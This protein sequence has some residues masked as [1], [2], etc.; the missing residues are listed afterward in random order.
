MSQDSSSSQDTHS[1]EGI[2]EFNFNNNSRFYFLF[3]PSGSVSSTQ[4][5]SGSTATSSNHPPATSGYV[6]DL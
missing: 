2:I 6:P 5:Q 1:A 3:I 4:V